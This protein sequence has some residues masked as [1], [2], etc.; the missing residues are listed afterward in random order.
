[1]MVKLVLHQIQRN[2]C[3]RHARDLD[4]IVIQLNYVSTRCQISSN[5]PLARAIQNQVAYL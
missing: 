3:T 4:E 1:M 2:F 5:K